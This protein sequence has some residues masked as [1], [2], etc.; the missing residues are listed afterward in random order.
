MQLIH[1][2]Q[3]VEGSPPLKAQ[4]HMYPIEVRS[5]GAWRSRSGSAVLLTNRGRVGRD[6]TL[7]SDTVSSCRVQ[8]GRS[9]RTAEVKAWMNI[10]RRSTA[11][12]YGPPIVTLAKR[13]A[14]P[15][16]SLCGQESPMACE[17]SIPL[18]SNDRAR[19]IVFDAQGP[20]AIA[21]EDETTHPGTA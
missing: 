17:E 10:T 2:Q 21:E 6:L 5:L 11:L 12:V 3:T 8:S 15:G 19:V 4:L 20:P 16:T 9:R 13:S 14:I 1:P 18:A 7:S